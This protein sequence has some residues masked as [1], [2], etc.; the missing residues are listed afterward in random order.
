MPD[1]VPAAMTMALI[2]SVTATAPS[3]IAGFAV[4]AKYNNDPTEGTSASTIAQRGLRF[5]KILI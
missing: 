2:N 1:L 3:A 5:A 4:H